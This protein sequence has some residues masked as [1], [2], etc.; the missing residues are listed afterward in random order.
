MLC[1]YGMGIKSLCFNYVMLAM[2]RLM[3]VCHALNCKKGGL[4]K[5]GHEDLRDDG[6]QMS[7]LIYPSISCEPG[8]RETECLHTRALVGDLKIVVLWEAEKNAFVDYRIVN[9][10]APSYAS[11]VNMPRKSTT[12]MN[13]L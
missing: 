8:I 13:I 3:N 7:K 11:Q 12:N 10:D 6:A 1:L 9:P 4:V 5:H 2:D